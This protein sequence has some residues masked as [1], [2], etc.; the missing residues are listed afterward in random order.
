VIS[1]A[2]AP[3]LSDA[4][5]RFPELEGYLAGAPIS[6][7]ERGA[8][9]ATALLK[10]VVRGNIALIGD[11]SG[12]VD[13]ITGEGLCQAFRQAEALAGAMAAGDLSSY[14]RLHRSIR[15]RPIFMADLMLSMD[16]WPGARRHVIRT[17]SAHPQWFGKLLAI[18]VG[19]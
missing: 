9:T 6:S 12:S 5:A 13:A 4:L 18:H 2:R 10:S 8:I 14:A 19:A 1:R 7:S 11:A 15:R 3:L 16:R 17:L